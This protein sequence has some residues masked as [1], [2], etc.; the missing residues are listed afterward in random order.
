MDRDTAVARIQD[1][2]GF[3]TDLA[4]KIILRLQESQRNL[5]Q[6]KTLPW[7]LIIEDAT[8]SLADR[9]N[10][11]TIET[12]FIRE[13]DWQPMRFIDTSSG[14]AKPKKVPKRTFENAIDAYGDLQD[15]PP[16][17]Y[18]L[19]KSD[20]YFFP[21]ADQAYTLYHSY[22]KKGDVLTTNIENVWLLNCPELLIGDAGARMAADLRDD[23]AVDLF[24]R[25][26][27]AAWQA[28]FNE[29]IMREEAARRQQVGSG[30]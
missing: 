16:K 8:L 26:R 22:Y 29:T 4:A 13:V 12:G 14:S 30:L 15:G 1:G 28:V 2:L 24:G 21:T 9:A 18:V 19:R 23:F 25:M 7:F 3:R 17:V 11:V 6:G 20:Y 27:D 5:E 10:T